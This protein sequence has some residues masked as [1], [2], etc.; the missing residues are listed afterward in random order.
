MSVLQGAVAYRQ[1]VH[2]K[3]QWTNRR[4]ESIPV[5]CP[6]GCSVEYDLIVSMQAS[7]GDVHHWIETMLG[8]MERECPNHSDCIRF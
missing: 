1:D 2:E 6:S 8:R 5:G 7:D 4:A 3:E